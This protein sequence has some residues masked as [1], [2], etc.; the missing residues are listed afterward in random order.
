M[1][2]WWIVG[3]NEKYYVLNDNKNICVHKNYFLKM[4]CHSFLIYWYLKTNL[5]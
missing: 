1:H 5:L 4:T 2:G 3:K